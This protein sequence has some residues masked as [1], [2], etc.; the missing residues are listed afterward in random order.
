MARQLAA[1]TVK[2]FEALLDAE[3]ARSGTLSSRSTNANSRK[4][5]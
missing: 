5:A 4:P 1:N 3:K 2:R